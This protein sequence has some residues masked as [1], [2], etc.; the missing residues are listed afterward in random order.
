MAWA[1]QKSNRLSHS[2]SQ[3]FL[4]ELLDDPNKVL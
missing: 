1:S 4:L 3:R 2:V